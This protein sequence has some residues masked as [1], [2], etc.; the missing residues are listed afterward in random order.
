LQLDKGNIARWNFYTT[1]INANLSEPWLK[2]KAN[3][4]FSNCIVL[5][6][7]KRY[8]NPLIDYSFLSAYTNIVFVGVKAEHDLM[9]KSIP[10][11]FW[12]QVGDSEA[13]DHLVPE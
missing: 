4:Q 8:N 9:K 11:L 6:R 10:N 3:T 7:S 1:G 13:I 5:A 12:Q 2:V